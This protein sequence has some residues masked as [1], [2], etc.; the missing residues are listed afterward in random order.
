MRLRAHKF[1]FERF[2][3][4]LEVARAARYS[5][6]YIAPEFAR[7][8]MQRLMCK[9]AA[10]RNRTSQMQTSVHVQQQDARAE[11][12]AFGTQE[13]MNGIEQRNVRWTSKLEANAS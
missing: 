11:G 9:M 3:T 8:P 10:E 5:W 7:S 13:S 2:R 12:F 1:V 6:I 4:T